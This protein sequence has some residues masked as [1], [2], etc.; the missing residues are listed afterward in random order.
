MA[1]WPD[2]DELAKVLDVVDGDWDET[3]DRVLA[4]AVARVKRDVGHWDEY[5]DQPDDNL[6][7][8]ALRMGELMG[9]RPQTDASELSKDPTYRSHLHGH[10]RVFGIA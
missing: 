2:A 1:Q 5:E 3:I 4:A 8:A 6:A 10:R 9:S 7:A